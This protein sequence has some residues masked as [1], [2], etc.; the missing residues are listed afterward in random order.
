MTS[1]NREQQLR[2]VYFPLLK[3][4]MGHRI[5]IIRKEDKARFANIT[6]LE[7]L[8][9]ISVGQGFDWPDTDILERQ[10]FI[11]VYGADHHLLGML[12]KRRFVFA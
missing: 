6:S 10:G 9:A 3:V 5:A 2:A 1:I 12:E 8:Q 7:Q 4:L 11:L